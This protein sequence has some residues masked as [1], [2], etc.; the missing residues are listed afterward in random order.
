LRKVLQ[1]TKF[2]DFGAISVT[3]NS[4]KS[5]NDPGA[6]EHS[7]CDLLVKIPTTIA[8]AGLLVVLKFLLPYSSILLPA[9]F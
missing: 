1:I 4:G 8:K 2:R 6:D 9:I 5:H 3:I 7:L